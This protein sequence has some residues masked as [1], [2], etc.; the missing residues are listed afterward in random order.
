MK[1]NSI[2]NTP[3]KVSEICLGTMTFGQ[4][5]TKSDAHQQLDFAI[6]SGINFID[7][8]ISYKKSEVKI[9]NSNQK[10]LSII[11]KISKIPMY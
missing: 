1:Q 5:N 8:A 3:L 9:G 2:G 6:D 7:T 11:T 10:N 4:Q